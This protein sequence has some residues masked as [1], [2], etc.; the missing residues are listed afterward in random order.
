MLKAN[1]HTHTKRCGHAFGE[2][3]EYV[4]EALGQGMTELGFSDHIMLPGFSQPNIRGDYNLYCQDY[5]VSINKLKE[6]YK[7]RINIHLGFEAESFQLYFPYYRE[8]LE[9]KTIDYLILGN[10]SSMNES[11]EISEYFGKTSDKES[12]YKYRDLAIAALRTGLFSCFA[13]PDYFMSSIEVVDKEVKTVCK[14][15]IEVCM[16]LDIPLEVNVAGIRNGFR[17]V[18]NTTRYIYPTDIFFE[19]A[20][21]MGAK[22]IIGLDAHS[23]SQ[24]SNEEANIKAILFA[25]KHNLNLIDKLEFKKI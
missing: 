5:F 12:M 20:G 24:I 6:K 18:G 7:N 3:E 15:L 17:K 1:Y 16:E 2:D 25:R 22:C 13:H 14:Q 11:K 23:P 19:I 21:K 8:L 10:H 9:T 4:L